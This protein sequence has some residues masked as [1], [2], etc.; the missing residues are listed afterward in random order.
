MAA[1]SKTKGTALAVIILLLLG[2]GGAVAVNQ[3]MKPQRPP[4][5]MAIE[6]AQGP[7]T[8]PASLLGRG[9]PVEIHI[10]TVFETPCPNPLGVFDK[11]CTS[12]HASEPPKPARAVLSLTSADGQTFTVAGDQVVTFSGS[13]NVRTAKLAAT[14]PS[15]VVYRRATTQRVSVPDRIITPR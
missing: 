8:V 5:P 1:V 14:R 13:G 10:D 12:C 4:R 9:K 2:L 7:A 3:L 15:N 6:K 11:T